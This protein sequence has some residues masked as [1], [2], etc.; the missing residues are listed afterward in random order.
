MYWLVMGLVEFPFM[1]KHTACQHFSY[2][3]REII[4]SLSD[5]LKEG[6]IGEKKSPPGQPPSTPCGCRSF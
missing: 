5:V 6:W 1:H 2:F 4:F 3:Y